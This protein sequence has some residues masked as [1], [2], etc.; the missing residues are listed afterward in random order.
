[1]ATVWE[2]S[3]VESLIRLA[4]LMDADVRGELPLAGLAQITALEDRFGLSPKAR[5]A[6]QWEITSGDNVSPLARPAKRKLRAVG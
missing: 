3:D 5:R 6:L 4:R 2:P 1:M